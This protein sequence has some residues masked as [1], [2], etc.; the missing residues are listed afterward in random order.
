MNR[1]VIFSMAAV[2]MISAGCTK[3]GMNFF[4]GT[5]GYVL[6]GTITCENVD[7][8]LTRV[9]DISSEQGIMHIEPVG[10]AAVMTLKNFLGGV[11]VFKADISGKNISILS[12]QRRIS[13]GIGETTV[14]VSGS[15]YKTNDLIVCKL[16]YSSADF[17]ILEI[18]D[19]EYVVGKVDTVRYRIKDS[20]INLVASKE[21]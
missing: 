9:F 3:E 6:S 16:K 11:E 7:S 20:S 4:K 21:Q 17:N 13:V 10:I 14:T 2:L 19:S 15:G 1:K 18:T 12:S 5:Y 8:T